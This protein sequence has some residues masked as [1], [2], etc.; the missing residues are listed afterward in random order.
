MAFRPSSFFGN[1]SSEIDSCNGNESGSSGSSSTSRLSGPRGGDTNR[2]SGSDSRNGSRINTVVVTSSELGSMFNCLKDMGDKL[3]K[4]TETMQNMAG[5]IEKSLRELEELKQEVAELKEDQNPL[6]EN[7][8][9]YGKLPQAVKKM[10]EYCITALKKTFRN[11]LPERKEATDKKVKEKTLTSRRRRILESEKIQQGFIVVLASA[12]QRHSVDINRMSSV[13]L[14]PITLILLLVHDVAAERHQGNLTEKVPTLEAKETMKKMKE[15]MK[16]NDG[17]Q[18]KYLLK[19]ASKKAH[20]KFQYDSSPPTASI[21]TTVKALSRFKGPLAKRVSGRITGLKAKWA[22]LSDDDKTN[23]GGMLEVVASNVE[24]FGNAGSDPIGA[25]QGAVN[26]I[27]GISA[28]LGPI[29]PK[30]KSMGEIVREQV[31][32]ALAKYRED[33]LTDNAAGLVSA[34]QHTKAYLNAYSDI[35]KPLSENE[36]ILLSTRIPMTYGLK[37]MGELAK[38]FDRIPC[39]KLAMDLNFESMLT[40]D[41]LQ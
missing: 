28:F 17:G 32:K 29:G 5:N 15:K 25:V 38:G 6:E 4:Q 13:M 14:L 23:I 31:E 26:I 8:S 12:E 7:S 2:E 36:A 37:F 11:S 41:D 40:F 16:G 1:R 19:N 10:S 33:T 27:G 39:D 20:S 18:D 21:A 3:Q 22:S 35:D 34:F 30:P 24:K 9:Y